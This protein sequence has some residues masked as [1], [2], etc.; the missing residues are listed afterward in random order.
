MVLKGL[1]FRASSSSTLRFRKAFRYP[2][3]FLI[4]QE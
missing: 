1:V 3:V 2:L 4:R